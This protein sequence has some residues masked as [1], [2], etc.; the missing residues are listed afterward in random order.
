M[1]KKLKKKD[2]F[3]LKSSNIIK[4]PQFQIGRESDQDCYNEN[5]KKVYF[6]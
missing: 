2:F 5:K 1:K 4:Q 3:D 6:N